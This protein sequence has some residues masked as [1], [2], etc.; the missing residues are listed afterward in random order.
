MAGNGRRLTAEQKAPMI[1]RARQLRAQ[2]MNFAAIGRALGVSQRTATLWLQD[3]PPDVGAMSG[4]S[5]AAPREKSSS[6]QRVEHDQPAAQVQDER[7]QDARN[8]PLFSPD[9]GEYVGG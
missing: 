7:D 3:T 8:R 2:G 1:A 6:S 9:T 5:D 4:K